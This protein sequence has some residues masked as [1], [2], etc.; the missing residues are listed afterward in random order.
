MSVTLPL[1]IRNEN[2]AYCLVH[3]G[4][5]HL[6]GRAHSWLFGSGQYALLEPIA[7]TTVGNS[8]SEVF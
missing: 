1:S 5:R 3:L 8:E 4:N 6:V 7:K 2:V